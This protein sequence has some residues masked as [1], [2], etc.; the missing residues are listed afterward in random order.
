[1]HTAFTLRPYTPADAPHVVEVVNADAA[2]TIGVRRAVVDD[3]GNVRLIRYV[4]PTSDKVVAIDAHNEIVG[5][6]YLAD[7]DQAIVTEVGGDVHPRYWGQGIGT[8]LVAW[9]EERAAVL[10][11]RV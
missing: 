1:M 4:P 2:Q 6:A 11:Q 9:A 7:K 3:V 5:Y 8:S 10:D